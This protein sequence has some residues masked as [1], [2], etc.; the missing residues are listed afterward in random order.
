MSNL[1]VSRIAVQAPALSQS[2]Q[3]T[4][5][6]ASNTGV[7]A[8]TAAQAVSGQQAKADQSDV[9]LETATE[10]LNRAAKALSSEL[11]FT[12][13]KATHQIIVRVLD[14]DGNVIREIP[15]ERVLDAYA[16]MM[17]TLG[18]LVDQTA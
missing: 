4:A 14:G 15:P 3:T 7:P 5:A 1:S 8:W 11:K 10:R 12:V 17:D 16:R 6:A 13:H 9:D 2:E 18:L